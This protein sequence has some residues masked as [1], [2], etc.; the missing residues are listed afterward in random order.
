MPHI[1]YFFVSL[2]C[3]VIAKELILKSAMIEPYGNG[4]EYPPFKGCRKRTHVPETSPLPEYKVDLMKDPMHRW[5]E[6]IKDKKFAMLQLLQGI[7]NNTDQ[8]FGT[9]VFHLVDQYLPLLTDTL[10]EPYKQELQGVSHS[11][12]MSLGD[13]TLFN[14][15]YEFFSLC[16]SILAQD[17]NRNIHHARNLDFGLFLGWDPATKNWLT[18]EHLKPLVI[19][20]VFVK[21]K[22]KIFEAINFAGYIGILTGVKKGAFSLSVDERFRLNGGYIGLAEWILGHHSQQWMGLLTRQVMEQA[23]S[24]LQAQKMLA[25]PPLVAPVYFILG[26]SQPGEGCIITRDRNKFDILTL[27]QTGSWFLVQTNYDHWEQPPFYDNRRMPAQTCLKY[28]GQKQLV[29]GLY[30][31]LSTRPVLNK[32]TIYTALLDIKTGSIKSWLRF[33]NNPCWPW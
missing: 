10:P 14:V 12:N 33:C 25:K 31:V 1:I 13:I 22:T 9:S 17:E 26:S 19:K 28:Y 16:T 21:G 29:S 3:T 11:A 24:Y 4:S 23:D 5:D 8:L 15:F 7:R 2:W 6:V 20:V 32:L 27:S 30:N 18:T